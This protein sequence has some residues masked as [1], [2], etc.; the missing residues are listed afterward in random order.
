MREDQIGSAHA[1]ERRKRARAAFIPGGRQPLLELLKAA[2]SN[3]RHQ[4][5]AVAEVAVGRC[6][7]DA[8]LAGGLCKGETRRPLLGN[9]VQRRAEQRLAQIAVMIAAPPAAACPTH[10]SKS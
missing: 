7:A 4:R 9:E 2:A 6:R 1:L 10:E 5:I 3:I 8:G